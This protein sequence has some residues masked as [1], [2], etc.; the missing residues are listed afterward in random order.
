MSFAKC[1]VR[2][3][4]KEQAV[5]KFLASGEVYSTTTI[6]ADLLQISRKSA[7][8]TLDSLEKIGALTSE[9]YF[10]ATTEIKRREKSV[11]MS[12]INKLLKDETAE[13]VIANIKLLQKQTVNGISGRKTRIYGITRHGAAL[14]DVFDAPIFERGSISHNFINHRLECQRMRI[15]AELRRWTGW[16]TERTLRKGK[17][18]KGL[19][20]P[21]AFARRSDGKKVAIELERNAK[22]SSR[23]QEFMGR[24]MNEILKGNYDHVAIICAPE[25][26]NYVKDAFNK[27]HFVTYNGNERKVDAGHRRYFEFFTFDNFPFGNGIDPFGLE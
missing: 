11:P 15:R 12:V 17:L 16:T 22:T 5:L 3:F 1:R 14:A 20:M 19:K 2:K 8:T 10:I 9:I 6:L 21:D 7:A 4:E 13:G 23:Y 25:I 27:I 26:L 24:Y 18:S